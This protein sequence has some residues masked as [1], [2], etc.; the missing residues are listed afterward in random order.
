MLTPG[1]LN[2]VSTGWYPQVVL[3][4]GTG[5]YQKSG[6]VLRV[7]PDGTSTLVETLN[8]SAKTEFNMSRFPF[9]R[10]HLEAIFEVLGFDQD[11]VVLQVESDAAIS[12]ANA[13]RVPQWT[14]TG[15]SAFVRDRSASYAG[16]GGV[17]S[18]FIVSLDVQRESF[19]TK[20]LII[21]PLVVIVLL[22]FSVFWM[23]RSSLGDRISVSFIGILTGVTYQLVMSDQL[24]R[25]SYFTLMHGFLS[26]SFLTMSTTV[27][28]NLVVE[29]LDQH[30][31]GELG[32]RI[33]R[34]CRWGFPL[35]Y[36]GLMLVMVGVVMAFF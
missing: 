30:G 32:D 18:A 22:S 20:R 35:A 8:A 1:Q 19:Y 26:L 34:R 4:N 3:V 11:E 14:I 21:I 13:V 28:I 31:K 5:L 7:Q 24:P 12:Y 25:I 33:D 16:R 27:V 2:E 10:H 23:D 36:F 6:V 17:S 15:A 9:D 29:A